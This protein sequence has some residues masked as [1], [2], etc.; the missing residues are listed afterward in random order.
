VT[1][2]NPSVRWSRLLWPALLV[3]LVLLALPQAGFFWLSFFEDV[4]LGQ[5]GDVFILE[6]YQRVVTDSVYLESIWL[7]I[8]L[9]AITV[10]LV[11]LLGFPTAYALARAKPFTAAVLLGLILATSLITV[12]IKLL[13]LNLILGSAGFINRGLLATGLVASPIPL[14]NNQVGVVIG[15]LQYTLPLF[16]LLMF[17]VLQTVPVNL[18]EAAE[19][20]GA[21]RLAVYTQVI[22]P[23]VKPGIIASSLICFNM[24]MG[25]FTSA[26][27]MGGGRVRTLPV[28]IQQ[29]IIQSNEYALGAALSTTL[30][31]IVFAI[32]LAV[33]LRAHSGRRR[34]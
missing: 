29:K 24:S 27:L 7:T 12:V 25:A 11:I 1:G 15:L 17:G 20:H 32:N 33:G 10:A 34:L 13:G 4:G 19:L 5:V 3:S 26:V 8:Y 2:A 21:S 30:L 28:L 6:N 16:V 31:V 18:E 23:L 22:V 9:S 14:I